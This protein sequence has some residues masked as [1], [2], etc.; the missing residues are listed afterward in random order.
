MS[1]DKAKQR[2]TGLPNLREIAELHSQASK[3]LGQ[4]REEHQALIEAGQQA[5]AKIA[6]RRV[7]KIQTVV[8]ALEVQV[9]QSPD[10]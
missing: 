1:K 8:R 3:K 5:Q 6:L 2:G 9:K 10:S 4:L 7:E